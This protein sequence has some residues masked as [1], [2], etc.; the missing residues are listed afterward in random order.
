M[1]GII[2]HLG[3]L[4]IEASAFDDAAAR[5][6]LRES[7]S[8]QSRTDQELAELPSEAV[9]KLCMLA[10]FANTHCEYGRLV[11]KTV[12]VS[13]MQ[14]SDLLSS[15]NSTKAPTH[16][17]LISS[18]KSS[19]TG[20]DLIDYT[21]WRQWILDHLAWP[22][23]KPENK[24][25]MVCLING[26]TT[27]KR[28]QTWL[29]NARRRSGWNTFYKTH[30]KS[31]QELM[32][33]LVK[34]IESDKSGVKP[35]A[36]KDYFAVKQFF[37][38]GGR[39]TVAPWL[40]NLIAESQVASARP[41]I[42]SRA[43]QDSS[44]SGRFTELTNAPITPTFSIDTW[45]SPSH[46][47]Q[48][49]TPSPVDARPFESDWL[50]VPERRAPSGR[51]ARVDYS[52]LDR[53][54]SPLSDLSDAASEYEEERVVCASTWLRENEIRTPMLTNYDRKNLTPMYTSNAGRH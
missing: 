13:L 19:Q 14:T 39:D 47:S 48:G 33:A 11:S 23:P 25:A 40:E 32:K 43:S 38:S 9:T 2:D 44:D 29:V 12:T 26:H 36:R 20:A 18:P 10:L 31:K 34:A 53:S 52:T 54:P 17:S 4:L 8:L 21:P 45:P 42:M 37:A 27:V 50:D 1:E 3:I 35:Q 30:A 15:H 6:A 24:H 51:T 22:F 41:M 28:L 7:I 16:H 49:V 46:A 5:Q